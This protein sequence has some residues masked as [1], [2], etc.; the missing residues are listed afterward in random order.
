MR[1]LLILFTLLFSTV[2][3]S[4][5]SFAEWTKVGVSEGVGTT[6]W[7]QLRNNLYVDFER[8]RKVDG[9]VYWWEL[10]DYL[11]PD[12]FGTFSWKA[13]KQGD[14]KLFR[15]MEL[16]GSS[17]KEPMSR[18]SGDR[19]NVKNPEWEYPSPNSSGETILKS[20]CDHVK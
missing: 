14:C 10:E 4:S 3:F 9:Y 1:K 15:F 11:K 16:S 7:K 12:K 2:M 19:W 13:Y 20:V 17:H 8:I 5:T 18:G 6:K